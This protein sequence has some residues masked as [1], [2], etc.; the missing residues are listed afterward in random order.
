MMTGDCYALPIGVTLDEGTVGASTFAEIEV[1]IGSVRKTLTDGDITFDENTKEFL[2]LLSQEET[3]SLGGKRKVFARFKF[4]NGEVLGV[5]LG[6]VEHI[7]STSK[8][9]L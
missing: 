5:E 4:A 9:V 2:V 7:I 6:D 8:E 3:F 1:M